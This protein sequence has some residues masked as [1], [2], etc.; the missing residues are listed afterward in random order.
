M[1][2]IFLAHIDVCVNSNHLKYGSRILNRENNKKKL[3]LIESIDISVYNGQ[4]EK[5]ASN[6]NL[7]SILLIL[8]NLRK[9]KINCNAQTYAYTYD[10]IGRM[11]CDDKNKLGNNLSNILYFSKFIIV[12]LT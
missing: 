12:L 8:Q 1:N 2:K 11:K 5:L 10:C 9:Y 4:I 6:S 3:N 7:P